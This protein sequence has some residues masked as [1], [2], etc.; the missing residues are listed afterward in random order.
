M[1]VATWSWCSSVVIVIVIDQRGGSDGRR[2]DVGSERC[3]DV[4]G[5]CGGDAGERDSDW[6]DDVGYE[7]DGDW[8]D[9]VGYERDGGGCDHYDED[10]R[11]G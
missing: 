6:R 2:Y 1:V 4:N 5:E 8:C 10:E 11:Q 3:G 7:R 9:Y